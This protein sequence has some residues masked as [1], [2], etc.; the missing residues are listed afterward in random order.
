[1]CTLR[2]LVEGVAVRSPCGRFLDVCVEPSSWNVVCTLGVG[3]RLGG[4]LAAGHGGHSHGTV[5][6]A[7]AWCGCRHPQ[8]YCPLQQSQSSIV[9]AVML[10]MSPTLLDKLQLRHV[11]KVEASSSSGGAGASMRERRHAPGKRRRVS[12]AS[13][14]WCCISLR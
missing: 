4:R 10:L 7:R 1:M 3:P 2:E 14:R 11:M 9:C 5:A 13:S 6:V 12:S 8:W